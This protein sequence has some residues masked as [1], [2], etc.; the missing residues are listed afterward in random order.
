[1]SKLIT[2]A[3][4]EANR[5]KHQLAFIRKILSTLAGFAMPN[6]LRIVLYRAMGIKIG[7]HVFIGRQCIIEDNFP[8]LITIEDGAQISSGTII[9]VHDSSKPEVF[10]G[11]VVIKKYAYLGAGSIILAG[12]TIGEKAI[13]GAGAVVTKDVEP[14]SVVVGVPSFPL[15]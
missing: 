11:P 14:S 12:V 4:Y 7:Q 15:K 3:E 13:V 2:R 5:P 1:M 9:F 8:E 10:I 6:S